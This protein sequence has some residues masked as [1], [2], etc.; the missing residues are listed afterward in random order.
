MLYRNALETIGNIG[1]VKVEGTNGKKLAR[2][3]VAINSRQTDRQT[4]E[5]KEYTDWVE[6]TF[7]GEKT[8]AFIEKYATK[9]A[10]VCIRGKVRQ[11]SYEKADGTRVFSTECIGFNF[12]F[13]QPRGDQAEG[14]AEDEDASL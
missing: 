3:S 1:K 10:H 8:V 13:V 9:G 14:Q 6:W 11:N 7:F 4:G 5:V 2:V 12:D